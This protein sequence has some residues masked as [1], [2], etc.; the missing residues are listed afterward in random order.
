MPVVLL[1]IYSSMFSSY[2]LVIKVMI[3]IGKVKKLATLK[4]D[5]GV[6]YWC[7]YIVVFI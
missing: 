1:C 2:K 4:F 3:R 6:F 5:L 7:K